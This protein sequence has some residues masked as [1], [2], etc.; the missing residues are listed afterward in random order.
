MYAQAC[1]LGRSS[2]VRA[3]GK[4]VEQSEDHAIL[5]RSGTDGS[6][7]WIGGMMGGDRG[8]VRVYKSRVEAVCD[9]W[10]FVGCNLR[11]WNV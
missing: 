4:V 5:L 3:G 8:I 10:M 1:T 7:I 2:I 9:L 11:G 6:P